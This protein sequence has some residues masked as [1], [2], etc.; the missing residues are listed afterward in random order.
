MSLAV[1]TGLAAETRAPRAA[2]LGDDASADVCVVGGGY[3][4]L[5][6]AL[7]LKELEPSCSVTVLEASAGAGASGRNASARSR[8]SS[9]MTWWASS[10]KAGCGRRRL[11]TASGPHSFL[12]SRS[13]PRRR[14]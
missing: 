1:A 9:T 5:W 13:L 4:G 10:T 2:P 7:R 12:P 8:R 3:A 14:A 6:T 11:A